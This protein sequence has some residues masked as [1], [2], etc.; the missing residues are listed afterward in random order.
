MKQPCGNL[1]HSVVS[2]KCQK[3]AIVRLCAI[4][5]TKRIFIFNV[6]SR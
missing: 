2:A 4:V 6:K 1:P 3:N 5:K